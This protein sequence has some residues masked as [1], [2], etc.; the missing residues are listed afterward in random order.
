MPQN[1]ETGSIIAMA[2]KGEALRDIQAKVSAELQQRVWAGMPERE[3]RACIETLRA[4]L[5]NLESI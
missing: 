2:D 1:S 4:V 3:G 5:R